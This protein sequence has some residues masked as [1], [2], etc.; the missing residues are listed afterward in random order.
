MGWIQKARDNI[1][2][3][4]EV[5]SPGLGGGGR[6]DRRGLA[7]S[8]WV[9]GECHWPLPLRALRSPAKVPQ[10]IFGTVPLPLH[11]ARRRVPAVRVEGTGLR[12]EP[13]GSSG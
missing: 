1:A 7:L 11:P 10:G 8:P 9:A 13:G 5:G 3:R 2:L 12:R 4:R 6:G